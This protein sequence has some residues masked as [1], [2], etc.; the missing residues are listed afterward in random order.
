MRLVDRQGDKYGLKQRETARRNL[1]SCVCEVVKSPNTLFV[2][3]CVFFGIDRRFLFISSNWTNEVQSNYLFT[4][5]GKDSFL[6]CLFKN[7]KQT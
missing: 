1:I 4:Y 7:K 5:T 2:C 3:V 6:F